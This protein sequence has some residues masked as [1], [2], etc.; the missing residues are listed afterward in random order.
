MPTTAGAPCAARPHAST[1]FASQRQKLSVLSA[2]TLAV[3]LASPDPPLVV[4]VSMSGRVPAALVPGA[5][6]VDMQ[7]LDQYLEVPMRLLQLTTASHAIGG[8]AA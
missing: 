2:S 3:L 4:D 8:D 7:E 6:L 5:V 1:A